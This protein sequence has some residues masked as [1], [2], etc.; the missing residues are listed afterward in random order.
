MARLAELAGVDVEKKESYEK[1]KAIGIHIM[2]W[3]C[4]SAIVMGPQ[5]VVSVTHPLGESGNNV[6]RSSDIA[7]VIKTCNYP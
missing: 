6:F 1:V 7:I 4:E 2:C 5:S 3:S